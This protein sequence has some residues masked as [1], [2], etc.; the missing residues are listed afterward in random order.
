M[1]I[2]KDS[3]IV[4][5]VSGSGIGNWHW[6]SNSEQ[7]NL[8]PFFWMVMAS[9]VLF[10]LRPFL[11]AESY[12]IRSIPW[13]LLFVGWAYAHVH[14]FNLIWSVTY[15]HLWLGV[16]FE[17]LSYNPDGIFADMF[18]FFFWY[19][20]TILLGIIVIGVMIIVVVVVGPPIFNS[21]FMQ[22]RRAQKLS[23]LNGQQDVVQPQ[24]VRTSLPK[25]EKRTNAT[26]EFFKNLFELVEC[27]FSA[28]KQKFCPSIEFT[29]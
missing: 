4:R 11:N 16:E 17:K 27:Y 3:H 15:E 20:V 2:R 28:K 12:K 6:V 18:V 29:E 7:R 24:F 1:K 19:E 9:V 10:P 13:G 23:E 5:L 22:N 21:R 14:Y 8:C 25:P 26:L